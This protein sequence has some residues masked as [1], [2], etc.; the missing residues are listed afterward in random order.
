MTLRGTVTRLDR[1]LASLLYLFTLYSVLGD[2]LIWVWYLFIDD[3]KSPLW[4]IHRH[5]Y[6]FLSTVIVGYSKYEGGVILTILLGLYIFVVRNRAIQYFVRFHTMQ[7]LFLLIVWSLVGSSLF[8]LWLGLGHGLGLNLLYWLGGNGLLIPLMSFGLMV[9][10]SI[11]TA[12][13][14]VY[15]IFCA[16][17]GKYGEIPVLSKAVKSHLRL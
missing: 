16:I 15:S 7:S 4:S 11:A 1:L 6:P 5:L 14:S 9:L 13:A 2:V 17:V 8:W 12:I 10:I 3:K